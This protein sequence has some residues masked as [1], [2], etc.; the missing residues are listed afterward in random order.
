MSD[1]VNI[2][3]VDDE[4]PALE[5][6]KDI[7]SSVM[8]KARLFLGNNPKD[9]IKLAENNNIAI[10]FLDVEMPGMTGVELAK[11][12]QEINPKVNII[13]TTAYKE[14]ALDAISLFHS[15]YVL[16]PITKKRISEQ[17][18]N[19]R[20]PLSGDSRRLKVNCFG[21][22]EIYNKDEPVTFER[23]KSKELLAYLV[24]RRGA[25]VTIGEIVSVIY[26][27]KDDEKKSRQSFYSALFA[28]R[29]SLKKIDFENVLIHSQNAYAVNTK[30]LDCDYFKYLKSGGSVSVGEYMR[31]YDWAQFTFLGKEG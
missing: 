29:K 20:F 15:G 19:L 18:K 25:R 24:H 16:K 2:L 31:Q 28:L 22:F 26:E 1:S 11:I 27:E 7:V 23:K 30:M 4:V 6:L 5:N 17:F 9:A 21:E 12:L 10:A 13:F 8:P 14:Y 3:L